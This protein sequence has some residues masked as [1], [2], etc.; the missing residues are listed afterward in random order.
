[1]PITLEALVY[2]DDDRIKLM[3]DAPTASRPPST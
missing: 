2:C 1:V 3:F